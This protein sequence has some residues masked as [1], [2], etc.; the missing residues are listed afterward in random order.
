[1]V[2]ASMV[3]RDKGEWEMGVCMLGR[4]LEI[5]DRLNAIPS[6]EQVKLNLGIIYNLLGRNT[7]AQELVESAITAFE[8]LGALPDLCECYLAMAKLKLGADLQSEAKFYILR[9]QTI[10]DR[11]DYQIMRIQLSC[12]WG[13]FYQSGQ[14]HIEARN[15]YQEGLA[16]S[17]RIGNLH[18]EAKSLKSL[19]LLALRQNDYSEAELRLQ[20]ALSLFMRLGA[21]YEAMSIRNELVCLAMAQGDHS[22]AQE[23]ALDLLSQEEIADYIDLNIRAL[24]SLADCQMANGCP[25]KGVE[26]YS[27]ALAMTKANS[28]AACSE[29]IQLLMNKIIK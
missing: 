23:M 3:Y 11:L 6:A 25:D 12:V 17:R 24:L 4:S 19:G 20:G 8:N 2:N 16:L 26:N 15:H 1:M 13:D 22:K 27:S 18:E 28:N 10:I 7:E 21:T 9:A 29:T 5:F 14:H